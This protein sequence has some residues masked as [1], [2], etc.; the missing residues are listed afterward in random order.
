MTQVDL[1]LT[2]ARLITCSESVDATYGLID[3]GWLAVD[4]GNI[5][6]RSSGTCDQFTGKQTIDCDNSFVSPGLI[7]C[8]T[9]LVFGGN[10]SDE[11]EQRLAGASYEEI[12]RA[13]GGILSTV[14]ATREATADTL[15][16]ATRKRVE[17]LMRQ[18]VT[19]VE[20]KSGYGLDLVSE[21]KMLQVATEIRDSM[22][23]NLKRTFLG[24]HCLPNE[25]QSDPDAYIDLVCNEML[26]QVRDHCDAVDVFCEDIAFDL[27]QTKRVFVAAQ[28]NDLAIKV[29]AEQ[30]SL[31]GS[32]K[33]AAEMGAISADHLEYLDEEGC[34]AMGES[35]CV[36]TLLPGAFYFINETQKPPVATLRKYNVPMA[37]ATD[38]NPG[39]S[40]L[41]SL[42]LSAN[43]ACTLFGLTSEEALLGITRNAAQALRMD[44]LG[45]LDVDQQADLVVWD[46]ESPSELVYGIGHNPCRQVFHSGT[47]IIDNT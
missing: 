25:Y 36:A 41:S 19:T 44:H 34:R 16:A 27:S 14:K 28:E 26:P 23:I 13:G 22:P 24:A 10:R 45:T 47:R 3:S 32:A 8:H 46:I 35:Q 17:Y 9:H 7:D 43:M 6:G 1:L 30:L 38:F 18:G 5:V 40:P 31:L 37:V 12:A 15:Y 29:H 42:L 20:I 11:W 2:N 4:Q 21:L 39:S 33:M